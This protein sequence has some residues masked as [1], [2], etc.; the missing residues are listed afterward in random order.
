MPEQIPPIASSVM[1][2]AENS[3]ESGFSVGCQKPEP[4]P[5]LMLAILVEP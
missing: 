5:E 4:K 2:P 1:P 3:L